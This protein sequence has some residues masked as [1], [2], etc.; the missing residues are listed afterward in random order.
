MFS[1]DFI[2]NT[3]CMDHIS[4]AVTRE[5][6]GDSNINWVIT[7]LK[8]IYNIVH[9]GLQANDSRWFS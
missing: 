3:S 8:N 9:L 7:Q 1:F 2:A 4:S 5:F 6:S